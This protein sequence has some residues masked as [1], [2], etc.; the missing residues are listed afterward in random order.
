MPA[1]DV[2][3]FAETIIQQFKSLLDENVPRYVQGEFPIKII[4]VIML[5]MLLNL[6]ESYFYQYCV[7]AVYVTLVLF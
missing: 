4:M 7:I 3:P 1:T 6:V 5:V 2:W